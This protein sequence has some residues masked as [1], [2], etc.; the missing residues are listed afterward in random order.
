M[1][2]PSKFELVARYA[3]VP[4]DEPR[5]SE[6]LGGLNIFIAGHEQ[7]WQFA[8]GR[9]SGAGTNQAWIARIQT[10]LVF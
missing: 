4:T 1:V 9:E 5:R 3:H 10:Q 6:A 7:K 8:G 2:I